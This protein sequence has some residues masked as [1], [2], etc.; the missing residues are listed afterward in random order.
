[1]CG[2]RILLV[3]ENLRQTYRYPHAISHHHP[4]QLNGIL[5]I[6]SHGSFISRENNENYETAALPCIKETTIVTS[7]MIRK[8]SLGQ[9][10]TRNR[11]SEILLDH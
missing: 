11:S 3:Y 10:L 7:S 6:V 4:A 8:H 5:G 1:M 2:K 9:Y